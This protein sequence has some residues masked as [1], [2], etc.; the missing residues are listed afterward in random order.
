MFTSWSC[1]IFVHR[2]AEQIAQPTFETI[3]YVPLFIYLIFFEPHIIPDPIFQP[4]IRIL[5]KKNVFSAVT[6]PIS[7]QG[8]E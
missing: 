7:S 2:S 3:I 4:R 5:N 1:L 8:Y 6:D